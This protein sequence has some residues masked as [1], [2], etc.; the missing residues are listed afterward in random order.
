[1]T[2]GLETKWDYSGKMSRDG[3]VRKLSIKHWELPSWSVIYLLP[4]ANSVID[5]YSV[6]E[7][8]QNQQSS[9]NRHY[10]SGD[11]CIENNVSP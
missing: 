2:S 8:Q 9:K 7:K 11:W 6:E 10:I 1:M 3:K 5:D 4:D